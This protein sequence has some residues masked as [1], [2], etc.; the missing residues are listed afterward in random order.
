MTCPSIATLGSENF[1]WIWFFSVFHRSNLLAALRSQYGLGARFGF[2]SNLDSFSLF[3]F[4]G[5][6]TT[7]H[8]GRLAST[9]IFLNRALELDQLHSP[10]KHRQL[11]SVRQPAA[12]R[13]LNAE[14]A[15]AWFW[16]NL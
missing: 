8:D 16:L 4:G 9:T 6:P 11:I 15:R 14:M 2:L 13:I 1:R 5:S 10:A 3:L 12:E 7:F